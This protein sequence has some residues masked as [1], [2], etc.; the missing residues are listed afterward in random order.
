M[1]GRQRAPSWQ[2]VASLNMGV[3]GAVIWSSGEADEQ[4]DRS[5]DVKP[6]RSKRGKEAHKHRN[7]HT[8]QTHHAYRSRYQRCRHTPDPHLQ[9]W[10]QHLPQARR[11]RHG[12]S[13]RARAGFICLSLGKFRCCS[14]PPQQEGRTGEGLNQYPVVFRSRTTNGRRGRPTRFCLLPVHQVLLP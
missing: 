1:G 8:E 3:V 7:T 2:R 6:N 5:L 9:L 12:A 4:V 11:H 14:R 10:R 13:N